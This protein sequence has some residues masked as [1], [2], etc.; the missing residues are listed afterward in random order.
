M[1]RVARTLPICIVRALFVCRRYSFTRSC[2]A[3]GSRVARISHVDLVCRAASTRD[4]K[5]FLL[6]NTHVNNNNLLDHKF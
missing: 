1:S 3:S 4:N 5:L 6:M 2:R